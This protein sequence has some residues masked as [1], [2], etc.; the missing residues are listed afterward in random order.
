MSAGRRTTEP[1]TDV[2]TTVGVCWMIGWLSGAYSVVV[3]EPSTLH[4]PLPLA[5]NHARVLLGNREGV[6]LMGDTR[7]SPADCEP[8]IF[9]W[10]HPFLSVTI[11]CACLGPFTAMC[12]H[13]QSFITTFAASL[14]MHGSVQSLIVGVVLIRSFMVICSH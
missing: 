1:P 6:D 9:G 7:F 12:S 10:R 5:R 13:V 8:W 14:I 3:N 2:C 11:V 4:N